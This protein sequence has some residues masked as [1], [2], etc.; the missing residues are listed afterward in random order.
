MDRG[1]GDRRCYFLCTACACRLWVNHTKDRT[2]DAGTCQVACTT[3]VW[4]HLLFRAS[5][6]MTE[7]GVVSVPV[8][9]ID[10]LSGWERQACNYFQI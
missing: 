2:L 7:Q 5:Q 1:E 4:F 8:S 9:A 10:F 3:C 6:H